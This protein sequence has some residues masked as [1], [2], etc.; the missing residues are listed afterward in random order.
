LTS[1]EK[2]KRRRTFGKKYGGMKRRE[3]HNGSG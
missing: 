1:K 3:Y 2:E